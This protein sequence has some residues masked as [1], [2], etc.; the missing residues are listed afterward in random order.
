MLI[1]FVLGS[2]GFPL[3]QNTCIACPRGYYQ[4]VSDVPSYE[5]CKR[6]I[7]CKGAGVYFREAD[8][9]YTTVDRRCRCN[10][11]AGSVYNSQIMIP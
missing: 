7:R 6:K 2:R 11:S 3:D 4:D 5:P 9:D 1:F 10:T 8:E